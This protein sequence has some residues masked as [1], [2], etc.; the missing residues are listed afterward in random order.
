MRIV[1]DLQA[2][3]TA[4]RKRGIGRYATEFSR[5][6]ARELNPG[7]DEL[8]LG[9]DGTYVDTARAVMQNLEGVATPASFSSYIYPPPGH[10]QGHPEDALRPVARSMVRAHYRRL[11]PDVLHVHSLFEGFI[12]H[13]ACLGGLSGLPGTLSSVTLYDL[14]PLRFAAKYL[15]SPDYR[16]WYDA[17]LE[18]LRRFD[19]FLCISEATR[20]DAIELLGLAPDRLRVIQGG[21]DSAF[22]PRDWHQSDRNELLGR[23]GIADRYV[24]FTGNGDPRKNVEGALHA[25]AQVPHEH[26][27]GVQLVLNQVGDEKAVRMIAHRAG[28]AQRDLVITGHVSDEHLVGLLQNC[29]VFFF[30]SL[31]EGFGLPALEAMACGAACIAGNNSSLPE[32][33]GRTDALF[34]ATSTDSSAEML[35]QV[36]VQAPFKEELQR[37]GL[38]RAAEFTWQR[39]ARLAIDAWNDGRDRTALG[40]TTGKPSDGPRLRM[41]IVTPLPP[42]RTG[43]ADY[44]AEFG[45]AIAKHCDVDYYV[46]G[47]V[48]QARTLAPGARIS[49]W[50]EFE[51]NA[52]L[53]DYVV[54]QI[55]NSPFH[56][57]MLDLIERF[58]GTVVLHDLFLSSMLNHMDSVEGHTGLF[59]KELD[60]SHGRGALAVL[61]GSGGAL[62]ARGR[63]PASRRVIDNALVVVSHSTAAIRLAQEHFP[64]LRRSRFA[65][66]PMPIAVKQKK[67][68]ARKLLAR[69]ALGLTDED[70]VVVSFGFL[71]DTKLCHQIIDAAGQLDADISRRLRL[72]FV[73]EN[74]GG[75][76]GRCLTAV[77]A[78]RPGGPSITITGFVP[79]DKFWQYAAAADCAVQLR[80]MSRGESSKTVLDCLAA[81]L[82]TIVND[83]GSFVDLPGD[84]VLKIGADAAPAEVAEA[85]TRLGRS[86]VLR[87]ALAKAG[88]E[89]IERVH[90][91][92]AVAERF[93]GVVQT[94]VHLGAD[95]ITSELVDGLADGLS[96]LADPAD[97][98]RSTETALH[99]TMP[100]LREPRLF[101]DLSEVVNTDHGTGIQRVVRNLTRELMLSESATE[102]RVVP[103]AH[104]AGRIQRVD[105]YCETVLGVPEG[106]TTPDSQF[107]VGDVLLL[108]DSAWDVPQR[109]DGSIHRM[110]AAGGRV[111]AMVYDLIPV[112]FP[113]YCVDY[114]PGIFGRWLS[115]MIRECD[116]LMCISK[117]VADDLRSWIYEHDLPH[118]AGLR[119]GYAHLGADLETADVPGQDVSEALVATFARAATCV[120]VGTVEPRK[121]H[122]LVLKVFDR[123]WRS[124]SDLQL[125]IMGKRGWNTE[126]VVEEIL[127]HPEYGSRLLWLDQASDADLDYSYANAYCLIQASDAEG[128]GLPIV[129]A[130]RHG[131]P[132][133]LSDIPVFREIGGAD[134]SYFSPGDAAGLYSRLAG[135][136]PLSRTQKHR[137]MTWRESAEQYRNL[138]MDG[139]WCH[140]L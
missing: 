90:C 114:M 23:W 84:T 95:E 48:D 31:Y 133:V 52:D 63:Y 104:D 9:L 109:F 82:P 50:H 35:T 85:I 83:Y 103:V 137:P 76:Y 6:V 139:G 4:S 11:A 5:A 32:V 60:Y 40:M 15:D 135:Q 113:H 10:P 58:P 42:E 38:T 18:M 102:L 30:P 19:V 132:L 126:D 119:I 75:E 61:D 51:G 99:Q 67:T 13:A 8:H 41:S 39:S 131:T 98:L 74:D 106:T 71:A 122:D 96:L 44:M 20:K 55:G 94:A 70:F 81:E 88:L 68:A 56:S 101:V 97:E 14:I 115:H 78:S 111:G 121:R 123:L 129:E 117:A 130:A 138:M 36:L 128:F 140:Y 92:T 66:L 65:Y 22:Q 45:P 116:F 108:L 34:D 33:V 59:R 24:L 69:G 120:M 54:Y 105:G 25:F 79:A 77:A 1:M 87:S 134:A 27:E 124:G 2:C 110:Q 100:S 86:E 49:P 43:I 12:E 29:D 26:R 21:V 62:K 118:R 136:A 46:A 89:Y 57:H 16:R 127:E 7:D 91:P 28:L 3:Q 107:G 17:K 80:A 112:R 93:L 37:H 72:I 73:G 125:V 47:D 64:H 53:Y